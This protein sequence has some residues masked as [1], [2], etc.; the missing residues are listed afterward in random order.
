MLYQ[1]V[2][3]LAAASLSLASTPSGFTPA[4]QNPLTVTFGKSDGSGGKELTK[5]GKSTSCPQSRE[6]WRYGKR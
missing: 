6:A 2:T 1:F 4:T 5:A 3:I